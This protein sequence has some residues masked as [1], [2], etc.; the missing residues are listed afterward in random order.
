MG[1]ILY[2]L[3]MSSTFPTAI[4]L[5]ESYLELTGKITSVFVVGAS[6]GEMVV[7]IVYRLAK[8]HLRI[9]IYLFYFDGNTSIDSFS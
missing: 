1:T 9:F 5:A 6:L 7:C 2:G 8:F 4:H 3:F